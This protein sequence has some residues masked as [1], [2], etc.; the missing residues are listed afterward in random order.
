RR[1]GVSRRVA[2]AMHPPSR[3][4]RRDASEDAS[5]RD[6]FM[7]WSDTEVL[8]SKDF[9]DMSADELRRARAIIARLVLPVAGVPS[10]RLGP[11]PRGRRADLR[12]TLRATLRAG[13][14][15]ALRWRSIRE[16]PPDIVILCDISG[17]ME[18]YS[19]VLM[20]FAHAL[21]VDRGRRGKG[22]RVLT[23]VFGTRL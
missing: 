12:A 16:R 4:P 11:D 18:R 6:A 20:C 8:R 10:R 22:G 2:E 1:P 19:Q 3:E 15:I 5:E 13:G 14:G 23:F 9:A 7:T 17:S 21:G